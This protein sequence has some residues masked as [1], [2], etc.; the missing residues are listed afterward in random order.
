MS[1]LGILPLCSGIYS[2]WHLATLKSR[3][4]C[5]H[6]LWFHAWGVWAQDCTT[7]SEQQRATQGPHINLLCSPLTDWPQETYCTNTCFNYWHYWGAVILQNYSVKTCYNSFFPSFL[8][9]VYDV[10][11]YYFRYVVILSTKWYGLVAK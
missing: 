6:L 10:C 4:K 3:R 11:I 7:A 8:I 2:C 1:P 9:F 5:S